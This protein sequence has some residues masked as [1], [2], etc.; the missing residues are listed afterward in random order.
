MVVCVGV[1]IVLKDVVVLKL[2]L[3]KEN[4]AG[5]G[6]FIVS[7]E[8]NIVNHIRKYINFKGI[9]ISDDI[10]MKSLKFSPI[11]NVTKALEAGCNLILRDESSVELKARGW[12]SK[13]N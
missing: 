1:L 11:H 7:T 10:C 6:G 4:A 13:E 9:I 12:G 3:G 5:E 2:E 8:A